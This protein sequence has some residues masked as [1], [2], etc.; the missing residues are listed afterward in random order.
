M[1]TRRTFCRNL[2]DF[3]DRQR[4]GTG[5]VPA[6]DEALDRPPGFGRAHF[7]TAVRQQIYLHFLAG[8]DAEVPQH[9]LAERDLSFRGNREGC[10]H[11]C[12][13]TRRLGETSST[14]RDTFRGTG[15][16][17]WRT[18]ASTLWLSV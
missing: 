14:N 6:A 3:F 13:S 7:Q 2:G 18:C 15:G 11:G 8:G 4:L 12:L 1:A 16:R 5:P 17:S 10:S 9:F